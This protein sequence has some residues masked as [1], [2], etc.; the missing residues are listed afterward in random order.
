[1]EE[2]FSLGNTPLAN[3]LL[4]TDQLKHPELEYPLDLMFCPTCTLVQIA[5][6]VPPEVLFS[7]YVYFSSVSDTVLQ[8]ARDLTNRLIADRS[9]DEHS[10]VLEI[11][12]NDGYLLRNY[13]QRSIPVLLESHLSE[14]SPHTVSSSMRILLNDCTLRGNRLM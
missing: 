13:L 4:T 6:T 10:F 14:G 12:S 11:A 2:I 3:A 5:E 8:N 7:N 9:L 1:L